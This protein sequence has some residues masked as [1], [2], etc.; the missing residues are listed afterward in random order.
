MNRIL[1]CIL[2]FFFCAALCEAQSDR[3]FI[4]R[5]NR[6]YRDGNY[7]KSE[8]EYKK[9]TEKNQAS[10]NGRYNLACSLMQQGKMKDAMA[11]FES[12][13]KGETS[14]AKLSKIYHN[15]GVI[16]QSQQQ[17]AQAIEMYK[18]SLR[19]NPADNET[20]YNL[21][22]CQK[23]LKDQPQNNQNK[24][25]DKNQDKDKNKDQKQKQKD[26]KEKQK[27]KKDQ[28][29]Q[30]QQQPKPEQNKMSKENAEQLL[31]AAI[32]NE[33]QVQDRM[34]R[35]VSASKRRLQKDW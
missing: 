26:E 10:T 32:R 31:D 20:R 6:L 27:D 4:R 25:Q 24:N 9:A 30:D 29:K 22:L 7:E 5:G 28:N 23:L 14:K 19:R 34:K 8:V 21:A 3:D 15:M 12:S 35:S 16:L 11:Q 18:N 33:K 13:L 17:Y 2:L 1:S